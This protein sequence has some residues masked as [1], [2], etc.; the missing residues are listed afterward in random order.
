MSTFII[1]G[2]YSQDAMRGMLANPEN[3]EDAVARLFKEIE[4]KLLAYYVTFGQY[5]F[6]VVVEAPDEQA[7]LAALAV[8]AATGG[9][10]NLCT[11]TALSTK[12]AKK[13]F[14]AAGKFSEKFRPAGKK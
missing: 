13:A 4:G 9:V 2:N 11:T 6:L 10:T 1:Q 8:V 14:E 7:V 5:D 3:R 12:E